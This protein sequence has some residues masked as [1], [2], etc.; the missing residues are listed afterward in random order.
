[1]PQPAPD[2][3]RRWDIFCAVVDN[4]GDIGVC[5]RLARQLAA[6][7]GVDVRLWIDDP[8][9]LRALCPSYDPVAA[10][11]R[12]AGIEVHPWPREVADIVPGDVVI[13]AFACRLPEPFEQAMVTRRPTPVWINLEY[14]SAESWVEDFHRRPS[15][16]PHL[17]L[18][19]H[20]FYPGFTEAAGGLLCET[21]LVSER[22]AFK[23]VEVAQFW[24]RLGLPA[25]TRG[26]LRVSLF[27]YENAAL[28]PLLQAWVDGHR[29]IDC[30]L[31]LSRNQRQVEAFLGHRLNVGDVVQR[32]QLSMYALPF[33]EQTD[34]DRLLWTCDLNFVRGEDSFVRAQWAAVPMIWQIYPQQAQA[35]LPKLRAFL[36][37]YCAELPP[38]IATAVRQ[39][40]LAWNGDPEG[41]VTIA[42][43][44]QQYLDRMPMIG[45]HAADWAARLAQQDDLCRR[46]LRYCE[47]CVDKG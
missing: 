26:A 37:R 15:P 39:L 41:A 31:P 46:L 32:G 5:W 28:A 24:A 36:D 18:T 45:R 23:G 8:R 43:L 35:H 44:W 33:V 17:P 16:H 40:M 20:F 11:Q 30:L 42:D 38:P 29:P 27:S 21:S 3:L 14:L 2:R 1:M 13:E 22:R 10:V 7:Y 4:F 25:P 34:Y 12:L 9:A 6:E 47:S 19:K